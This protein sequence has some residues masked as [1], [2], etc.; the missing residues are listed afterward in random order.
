MKFDTNNLDT[1]M[2][3]LVSTASSQLQNTHLELIKHICTSHIRNF[4]NHK[5]LFRLLPH[6]CLSLSV[7]GTYKMKLKT[8]IIQVFIVQI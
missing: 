8:S 6:T 3:L 5:L 4:S 2:Y 7:H 1:H